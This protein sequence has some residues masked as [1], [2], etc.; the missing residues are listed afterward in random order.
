MQ[1]RVDVPLQSRSQSVLLILLIN[2]HLGCCQL[3]DI[4]FQSFR[5]RCHYRSNS[6]NEFQLSSFHLFTVYK[7]FLKN[8][9]VGELIYLLHLD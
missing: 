6:S 2:V 7:G 1:L 3:E 5:A 8:N 9:N 4:T